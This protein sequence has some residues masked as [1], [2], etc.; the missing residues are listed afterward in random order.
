MLYFACCAIV[1][2][3]NLLDVVC[4]ARN[5]GIFKFG[6]SPNLIPAFTNFKSCSMLPFPGGVSCPFLA[7]ASGVNSWAVRRPL[8][9]TFSGV[10]IFGCGGGDLQPR[11]GGLWEGLETSTD[12]R[13]KGSI[14]TASEKGTHAGA[15]HPIPTQHECAVRCYGVQ[16]AKY[17]GRRNG[18]RA[19][20]FSWSQYNEYLKYIY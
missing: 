5:I 7:G 11:W 4:S 13:L 15:A 2:Y 16:S 14:C 12:R 9:R 20:I 10:D 19:P 17:R 8:F 3:D 6:S 18:K 1:P